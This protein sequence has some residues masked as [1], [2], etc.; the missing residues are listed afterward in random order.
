MRPGSATGSGFFHLSSVWTCV[1]YL[2]VF[3]VRQR[4]NALDVVDSEL[5]ARVTQRDRWSQHAH[6]GHDGLKQTNLVLTLKLN[7]GQ[8]IGTSSKT[9]PGPGEAP[10][11]IA[12]WERT[13]SNTRDLKVN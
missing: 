7:R 2:S 3:K 6:G 13:Q 9:K 8:R 12:C 10:F 4:R 1:R 11:P 5:V